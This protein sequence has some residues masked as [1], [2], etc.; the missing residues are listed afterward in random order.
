MALNPLFEEQNLNNST[1]IEVKCCESDPCG[2]QDFSV[3]SFIALYGG[4]GAGKKP[5]KKPG[6][7]TTPSQTPPAYL[8]C[9]SIDDWLREEWPKFIKEQGMTPQ[10]GAKWFEWWLSIVCGIES[11]GSVPCAGVGCEGVYNPTGAGG[12]AL[13]CYQITGNLLDDLA[14]EFC[15]AY[16]SPDLRRDFGIT[17]PEA[18]EYCKLLKQ[19]KIKTFGA[20]PPSMSRA[21]AINIIKIWMLRY[22]YR[23]IGP[24]RA[25][26]SLEDYG[27][28]LYEGNCGGPG[29]IGYGDPA[30]R[31]RKWSEGYTPFLN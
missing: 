26:E 9:R 18:Q 1:E 14:S 16:R 27:R 30:D 22:R 21:D 10:E 7:V 29:C 6:Q 12:G 24:R 31:H 11:N 2:I 25:G 5:G 4:G 15:R 8:P 19:L 17:R 13:G 23:G 28:R 3:E 20:K